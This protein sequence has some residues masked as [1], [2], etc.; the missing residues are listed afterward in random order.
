MKRMKEKETSLGRA[1]SARLSL[2]FFLPLVRDHGLLLK[3]ARCKGL[4]AKLILDA[5]SVVEVAGWYRDTIKGLV[6]LWERERGRG[7][8]SGSK[9][10][11]KRERNWPVDGKFVTERSPSRGR[12]RWGELRER[13]QSAQGGLMAAS[14]GWRIWIWLSVGS[15]GEE[16]RAKMTTS[17]R[18][19]DWVSP[20]QR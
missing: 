18:L 14:L 5:S 6:L 11:R 1:M 12:G 2:A 10:G 15:E 17:K 9:R 3:K 7:R 20:Q 16:E 8:G 13:H 4:F 19:G